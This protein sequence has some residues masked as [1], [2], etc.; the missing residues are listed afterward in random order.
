MK[1]KKQIEEI[2]RIVGESLKEAPELMEMKIDIDVD[3]IHSTD[4]RGKYW[5]KVPIVPNPCP[6]R[7][8][9]FYEIIVEIEE[10][11]MEKYDLDVSMYLEVSEPL[12]TP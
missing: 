5:W 12:A 11:I 4:M 8:S 7:R 10:K 9:L 2:A 1:D 3:H 6:K